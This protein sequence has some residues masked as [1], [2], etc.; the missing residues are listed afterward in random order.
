MR[1]LGPSRFRVNRPR[2]KW[3]I[4]CNVDCRGTTSYRAWVTESG[5]PKLIARLSASP[6]TFRIRNA[7]RFDEIFTRS[8]S[9]AGLR[10]LKSLVARTG[11]VRLA[12]R[13]K[14]TDQM[15][16][17]ASARRVLYLLPAL[18]PPP[19][20]P[21]PPTTYNCAKVVDPITEAVNITATGTTCA[22]ARQVAAFELVDL[23]CNG[24]GQTCPILGFT[25][26]GEFVSNGSYPSDTHYSCLR[27]DGE[28]VE[29]DDV[30]PP[31][32]P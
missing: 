29:F 24:G 6:A 2:V 14:V 22:T 21:P 13:V 18:P 30:T 17:S 9:G 15:G 32:S 25:C 5:R 26:T 19:P 27:N 31:P 3:T 28:D 7:A 10:L 4:D 11:R 1:L 16:R 12:V 20:P 8:Y 23:S